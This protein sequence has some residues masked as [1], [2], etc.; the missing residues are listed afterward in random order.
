MPSSFGTY[1][2]HARARFLRAEICAR[3]PKERGGHTPTIIYITRFNTR[4]RVSARIRNAAA[5]IGETRRKRQPS[6][7][8]HY[9]R[10]HLHSCVRRLQVKVDVVRTADKRPP[11]VGLE[12][13][14]LAGLPGKLVILSGKG[15]CSQDKWRNRYSG[16]SLL[17]LQ[18][19]TSVVFFLLVISLFYYRLPP[20]SVTYARVPSPIFC[21]TLISKKSSFFFF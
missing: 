8:L 9:A 20:R 4:K 17:R 6:Q 14:R 10:R 15:P 5:V 12:R 18:T 19:D 7:G 1:D 16:H 2:A 3:D 21:T 11:T 13:A